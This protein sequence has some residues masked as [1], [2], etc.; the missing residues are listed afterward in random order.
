M[1]GQS[2]WKTQES[3]SDLREKILWLAW[4]SVHFPSP[5]QT[6][7]SKAARLCRRGARAG[8]DK[9]RVHLQ[10]ESSSEPISNGETHRKFTRMCKNGSVRLSRT[11]KG[12][13]VEKG[14]QF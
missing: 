14:S 6:D 1:L 7:M 3:W 9:A 2:L 11:Y 10:L 13:A 4:P 5:S 12:S 8:M